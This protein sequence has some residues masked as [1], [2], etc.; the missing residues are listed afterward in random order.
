MIP[1]TPM[2]DPGSLS[3]L[4]GPDHEPGMECDSD[5]LHTTYAQ[6]LRRYVILWGDRE[7]LVFDQR[8]MTARE[9]ASEVDQFARG[10]IRLGIRRGDHVAVWLMNV[11]EYAIAEFAIT[12]LGAT[13]V[14]INIRYKKDELE[15][16]LRHS[17]VVA[18]ILSPTLLKTD[19]LKLIG[20][21]CRE[22]EDQS[23]PFCA[24]P[25][26]RHLICVGSK[27]TGMH[28]FEQVRDE[29]SDVPRD[30]LREHALATNPDDIAI[31]QYTSGTTAFPKAAML[32]QGQTLRNAFQM[33][34][35]AGFDSS[36]RVLSAMPMFHVGGSVCALLGNVTIGYKLFSPGAFDAG[37]TLTIIETEQITAYA[38]L[39]PMYLALRNHEDFGRRSRHTLTKG[40]T[41]GTPSILRMVAEDIGI[42]TICSLYGLSEG[43]P[44]V[45]ISHWQNDAYEKRI[46]TMGRPQPGTEIKVIDPANGRVLPKGQ[47]GE[48]CARGWTVMKGYYNNPEE[49]AKAIDSERWLHTGDAGFVTEDGYLVWTGRIKDTIRVGGE[50]VSAVEV[51]HLLC[52]HPNVVSAA[53]VGVPDQRYQEVGMAFVQ[54]K[55]GVQMS[56]REIIDYCKHKVAIFKVPKYV[57]FVEQFQTTGSGKVQKFLLKKEALSYLEE[58]EQIR[59]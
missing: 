6:A 25:T 48:I 33:A 21:I 45:C 58:L 38:G 11:A 37:E 3:Y 23:A 57:R 13:M 9:F 39:E 24:V 5:W 4:R 30:S 32:S 26:L 18:L 54:L 1:D 40:W 47:P 34:R 46:G 14:P 56:E 22:L 19:C 51:E 29:G 7:L 8:R 41:A 50:N 12:I 53:V 16:A 59:R 55:P 10:L 44:N 15:Y 27:P 31:L 42:R 20:E 36:D 2:P 52:T 43:S 35:R 17:D 49:T 28:S